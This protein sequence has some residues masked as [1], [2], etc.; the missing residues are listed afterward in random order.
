MITIKENAVYPVNST[1]FGGIALVEQITDSRH[2]FGRLL[3]YDRDSKE[4]FERNFHSEVMTA[5]N[6][7]FFPV[8]N[9]RESGEGERVAVEAAD[10]VKK[11]CGITEP[12][13]YHSL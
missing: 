11:L 4:F 13:Y 2:V 3:M 6:H 5:D 7:E 10:I 12:K 9:G 8:W 1:R